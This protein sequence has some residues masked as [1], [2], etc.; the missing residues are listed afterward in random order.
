[1]QEANAF[2]SQQVSLVILNIFMDSKKV[3]KLDHEVCG[4]MSINK[5]FS[6][7]IFENHSMSENSNHVCA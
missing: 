6:I 2:S 5:I 1:M 7:I 3:V 4:L